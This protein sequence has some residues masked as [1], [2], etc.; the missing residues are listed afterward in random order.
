VEVMD[1]AREGGAVTIAPLISALE[2][3]A[4]AAAQA[5]P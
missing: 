4:E 3:Q 1:K 5:S 2:K